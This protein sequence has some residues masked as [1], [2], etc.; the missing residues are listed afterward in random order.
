MFSDNAPGCE[1]RGSG[2]GG[3]RCVHHSCEE[4]S[5]L[6]RIRKRL[7]ESLQALTPA[8]GGRIRGERRD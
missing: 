5:R 1:L 7:S 2:V 4:A 3:G 6:R 8:I